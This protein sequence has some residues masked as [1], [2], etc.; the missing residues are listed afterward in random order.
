MEC[1]TKYLNPRCKVGKVFLS[2]LLNA[3]LYA[4]PRSEKLPVTHKGIY[5][6]MQKEDFYT[7]LGV[8]L[9]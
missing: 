6:M 7:I 3:S 1:P 2:S 4:A 9:L 5:L 8:E